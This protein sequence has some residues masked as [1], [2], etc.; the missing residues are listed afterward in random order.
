MRIVNI[1]NGE[2]EFIKHDDDLVKLVENHMGYDMSCAIKDL[3]ERADEVKYKTESNLLSYE[4][5]LEE[6]REGY[7]ELCDMLERMVNT[8]EKKKINKTTL[9]EIIDRMENIINRHI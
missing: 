3:V 5:S 8:L 4:L 7:L 6:S 9:Q 2:I 1:L